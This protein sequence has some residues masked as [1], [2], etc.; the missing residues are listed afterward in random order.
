MFWAILVQAFCPI[1]TSNIH[2]HAAQK[3][4]FRSKAQFIKSCL[5]FGFFGLSASGA[6]LSL[7]YINRDNNAN[8]VVSEQIDREFEQ[9]RNGFIA[10]L[11]GTFV[12]FGMKL[13]RPLTGTGKLS[14][15]LEL[16]SQCF[17]TA[18]NQ[19]EKNILHQSNPNFVNWNL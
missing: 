3:A 8:V 13:V 11:G 4:G 15:V 14:F 10:L 12:L 1:I 2:W 18:S 9:I 16:F 19:I 7:F 17:C 6:I 5:K